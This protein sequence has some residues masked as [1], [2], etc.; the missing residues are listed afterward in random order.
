MSKSWRIEKEFGMMKLTKNHN[1]EVHL[2]LNVRGLSQ[3]AASTRVKDDKSIRQITRRVEQERRLLGIEPLPI[4][5]ETATGLWQ[6]WQV[7]YAKNETIELFASV[8]SGKLL[9]HEPA[10]LHVHGNEIRL[11]KTKIRIT[12]EPA[13]A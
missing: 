12:L 8:E 1:P 6:L 10:P 13:K 9:L 11:G 3:S 2:N 5:A 7:L 4:D